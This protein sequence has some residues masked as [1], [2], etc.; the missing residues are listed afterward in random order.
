MKMW[1]LLKWFK[2]KSVKVES[3]DK[4]FVIKP[5]D[6]VTITITSVKAVSLGTLEFIM[7]K[8]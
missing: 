6:K 2:S 4:P 8:N 7:R 3:Y 1:K 5:E